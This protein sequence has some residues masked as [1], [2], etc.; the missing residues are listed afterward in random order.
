M[1]NELGYSQN[2]CRKS[3]AFIREFI[4][5]H[6]GE[7]NEK[8]VDADNLRFSGGGKPDGIFLFFFIFFLIFYFFLNFKIFN[9]YM[10]SQT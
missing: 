10:R 7:K 9:S 8:T 5:C 1:Y 4:S 2:A 6:S 3:V